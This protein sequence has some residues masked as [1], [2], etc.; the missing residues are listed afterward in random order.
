MLDDCKSFRQAS[1]LIVSS[2]RHTPREIS[3]QCTLALALGLA[4]A[5]GT[6]QPAGG[7]K[8]DG[9]VM[10][11]PSARALLINE[12]MPENGGAWLDEKGETDDWIEL[13]NRSAG[14]VAPADFWLQDASGA[15]VQLRGPQLV[16]GERR[17]F[18]ADSDTSQGETHLSFKLKKSGDRLL[19]TNRD[20][21]VL[22]ELSL[23]ALGEN[24][25]FARFPDAEGEFA[26]CR[27]ASP[28]SNNGQG[29]VPPAP[30]SLSDS[31]EF[32]SYVLPANYPPAPRALAITELAL[33]PAA[34][35]SAYIELVNRGSAAVSLDAYSLRLARHAPDLPWPSSA[36]GRIV[37]LP[38]GLSLSP[39]E[40]SVV[41]VSA[42]ELSDLEADPEFEGVVTLFERASLT[43]VD[44]V[45]FMSWPRGSTLMQ[46]PEES[47]S[48][49]YCTNET[50]GTAN[51]C[52]QLASRPVGDR[53]RYLRTPGDYAALA[54]GDVE[55]GIQSV[56]FVVDLAAPG[57]VH[58][59]SSARYA[60]HYTFV[61]ER[62]YRERVLDRCNAVEN[63]EFYRGWSEFSAREYYRVEGRRF[64]LGTL[65][66]H[67]GAGL[68]AVEYTYGDAISGAQMRDG[69]FAV[70]GHA[71]TPG[72]WRLRPQDDVQVNKARAIEGSVPLVGPNAPFE[73]VTY[74]P[75][76]EGTAF[77]TLRFVSARDLARAALGPDIILV[78]DDV[79]NDI[80]LVGGLITEAFQTPLAH[81]NV[82]SQNR[83]TPNASLKS[84]RLELGAFFEQLVR[85]DVTPAAVSVTPASADEAR[86]FWDSHMPAGPLLAARLDT[87]LRGVQPL[88]EHGLASLP[89]I[90]AKAAQLAELG[91]GRVPWCGGLD[92]I[93]TPE[94]P[95]AIPVVHS[96]EH[97]AASGARALLDELRAQS[98]FIADPRAR[99]AG[100]ARV[101]DTILNYPVD[102]ALVREVEAA[103][104]SRFG[105]ERVR[106]RSSSNTEDLP[107]FNGAGLY[108]ST[109]AQLGDDSHRVEDALRIV[110]ASL[111][112]ARAYDE[113]AYARIDDASV[114]MGV[115]VHAAF[116]TE[117]AN[118]VAVS[119][120]L[121]DP[122]RGDI[123]YLN[124][125]AGE[126]SVTNPA[127][128]VAT[129]QLVYR[130]NRDPPIIYQSG[131]SLL[132]A[133]S[134]T[135]AQV[136]DPDE[137]VDLSC[138]LH[139]VHDLFSPQLNA[140]G[141]NPWF[142]MEVEFKF[143]G[144]E[145]KLL[146]K[147]ARPHSF[148]RP[149]SFS[150]CR[151]L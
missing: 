79:P 100:L 140:A 39:G 36:E 125:Q 60:L 143:L 98:D 109:S 142:A 21:Q 41:P 120:N 105:S 113:R 106:F 138:A 53:L 2:A 86:A 123:Y 88:T 83:G 110:W 77:G 103:V 135:R 85:L 34:T 96:R 116:L 24:E 118:G 56:K 64:L 131:S 90:G 145:R 57:L 11:G 25:V 5:C 6:A 4:L 70:L 31:V 94:T 137:V 7:A 91:S 48:F 102:P 37:D 80:P 9:G 66:Q 81:V 58:L 10:P 149:V 8:P 45:D 75:L 144:P 76:T 124:A 73:G 119:R 18:W 74:Q 44:R 19:L 50:P 52:D 111:Y 104:R 97:I 55:L 133:L 3:R 112:N 78:T 61:R 12:V 115:L 129:E 148:G 40:R 47:A 59:L 95:F 146:I 84:A 17:V 147:Q 121:L 30:P 71:F 128:G 150:D 1:C 72:E 126:A 141:D 82:L 62:I 32:L 69:F 132:R 68:R 101:R 127:P 107:G 15:R 99:A 136:L 130:W 42:L 29:C 43:S 67:G 13:V 26:V 114:A 108:T 93:R 54:K 23:P 122:T 33:R 117:Q 92:E 63:E 16:G 87:S 134:S 22:D 51:V 89:A 46:A 35:G 14:P 139:T 49:R 38:L 27:Y 28:G 20:E 65:T 151:E